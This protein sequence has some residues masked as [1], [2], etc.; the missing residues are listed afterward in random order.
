MPLNCF[1]EIIQQFQFLILRVYLVLKDFFSQFNFDYQKA[2][3]VFIIRVFWIDI[4][5]N[6][7]CEI[8]LVLENIA[9]VLKTILDILPIWCVGKILVIKIESKLVNKETKAISE[10]FLI[11]NYTLVVRNHLDLLIDNQVDIGPIDKSAL[12]QV[13]AND[14]ILSDQAGRN[15]ENLVIF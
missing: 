13:W 2:I 9:L 7:L 4:L 6:F 1:R 8:V 14:I 11:P 5:L 12:I 15:F 10:E 3:K